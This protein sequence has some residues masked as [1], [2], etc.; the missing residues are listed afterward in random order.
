M[1][2][3]K[4]LVHPHLAPNTDC[5]R[6]SREVG[7]WGKVYMCG[8]VEKICLLIKICTHAHKTQNDELNSSFWKM[9]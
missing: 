4:L 5:Q 8:K 2:S 6:E 1:D 3:V 9:E 7:G